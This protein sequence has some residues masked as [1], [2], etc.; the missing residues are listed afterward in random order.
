MS[1]FDPRRV[2]DGVM[3]CEKICVF[4]SECYYSGTLCTYEYHCDICSGIV[5][6]L[7]PHLIETEPEFVLRFDTFWFRIY[8]GSILISIHHYL[9][10]SWIISTIRPLSPTV[11]MCRLRTFSTK[12]DSFQNIGPSLPSRRPVRARNR[13]QQEDAHTHAHTPPTTTRSLK[14]EMVGK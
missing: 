4:D 7:C 2:T 11:P 8:S 9:W 3:L 12:Y 5:R 10:R 14:T 6:W 1:R 13:T